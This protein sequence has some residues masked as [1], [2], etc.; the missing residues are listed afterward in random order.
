MNI[1]NL[2]EEELE[3]FLNKQLKNITPEELLKELIECGLQIKK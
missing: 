2:N 1:F 3:K